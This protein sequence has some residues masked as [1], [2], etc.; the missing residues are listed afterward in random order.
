MCAVIK[1]E[2]YEITAGVITPGLIRAGVFISVSHSHDRCTEK[3]AGLLLLD[4]P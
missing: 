1:S 3:G 2:G 4:N